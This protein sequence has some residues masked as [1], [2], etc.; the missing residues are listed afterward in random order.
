MPNCIGLLEVKN[1]MRWIRTLTFVVPIL[2]NGQ[3]KA[4]PQKTADA[5]DMSQL[6][7]SRSQS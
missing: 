3:H 5:Q 2:L 1:I 7:K 6:S 4:M